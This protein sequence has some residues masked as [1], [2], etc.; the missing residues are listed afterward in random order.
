MR[1]DETFHFPQQATRLLHSTVAQPRPPSQHLAAKY[2]GFYYS[3][4]VGNVLKSY[5][6]FV[7]GFGLF[8]IPLFPVKKRILRKII[9]S[10]RRKLLDAKT[11]KNL[12]GN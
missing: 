7:D 10:S 6:S 1:R 11:F 8:P 3:R 5:T 2:G 9:P 4:C 12:V